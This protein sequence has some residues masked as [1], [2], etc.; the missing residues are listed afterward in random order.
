MGNHGP[1]SILAYYW[2]LPVTPLFRLGEHGDPLKI[3]VH[4]FAMS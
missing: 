2:G 4:E 3:I 1:N